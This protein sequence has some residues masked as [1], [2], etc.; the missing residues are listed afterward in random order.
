MK[1][2][3]ISIWEFSNDSTWH[4]HINYITSKARQRIY[5][6]RRLKFLLDRKSLNRAYISFIRPVLEYADI[7]W[8]NCTQYELDLFEKIQIE[9]AV[10]ET[11]STRLVSIELL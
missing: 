9:T 8:D 10:I 1:L 5:I 4:K 6:I 3:T 11:G 2:R 7:V